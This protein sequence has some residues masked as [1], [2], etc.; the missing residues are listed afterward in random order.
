MKAFD[1]SCLCGYLR[2]YL[3][4]KS[5]NSYE[6]AALTKFALD[7]NYDK[8]GNFTLLYILFCIGVICLGNSI[9]ISYFLLV[10]MCNINMAR[11]SRMCILVS[12]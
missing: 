5:K 8:I 10:S 11:I 7:S 6:S 4:Q 2:S 1:Y 3:F 12:F 9:E